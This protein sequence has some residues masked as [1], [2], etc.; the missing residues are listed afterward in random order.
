MPNSITTLVSFL[1]KVGPLIAAATVRRRSF[2]RRALREIGTHE[3][4]EK[5]S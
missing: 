1:A 2:D 3:H 4:Y 5:L